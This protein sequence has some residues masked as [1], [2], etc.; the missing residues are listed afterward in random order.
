MNHAHLVPPMNARRRLDFLLLSAEV[1]KGIVDL[2]C[3][4][5]VV[6]RIRQALAD[7]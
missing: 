2:P 6:V 7:P 5:D 4:P 3:F 1:S